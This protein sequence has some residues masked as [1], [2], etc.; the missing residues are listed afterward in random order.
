MRRFF[1]VPESFDGTTVTLSTDET[2]HLRDVLRLK[3]GD[4][5]Y[6][7]DGAGREYKCSVQEISK[8]HSKLSVTQETTPA[9]PESPLDLTLAATVLNGERYDLIVQKAV[10]LGVKTLVPLITIRCEAKLKDARRRVE[11]WQRIA[12]EATKQSGRATLMQIN[13]PAEFS[14]LIKNAAAGDL[15]MFSERDGTDF[16]AVPSAKK[17]TAL[18]GPKGGWDDSE[19]E[20]ARSLGARVITLGGRILRAETAAIALTSLLQHRYGDLK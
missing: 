20:N 19:L 3:T 16:S 18:I 11:R 4:E 15:V 14:D 10:E 7:F 12:L 13:E 17:L 9:S 1:A 2:R 8:K 5:V 6:V